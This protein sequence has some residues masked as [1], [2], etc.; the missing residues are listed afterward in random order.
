MREKEPIDIVMT[1][2]DGK[3]PVW[4]KKKQEY[5]REN[6]QQENG[7][8]D[9][10]EERYRDWGTL[11]Y[12][13]RGVEKYAPWVRNIYFVTEGHYPQW[14]NRQHPK[15]KM[16][17]H[18]DFIPEE[19]LPTFN[20]HTIEWNFHRIKGLSEQFIYFND[21][22]FLLNKTQPEYFF[23]N[24][25]PKDML[26]FQPVIA[27]PDNPVMSYI[28]LNNIVTLS[29]Y[30]DKREN[31]RKQPGKYFHIG[32]PPLYF[33]YNLLELV[34]PRY[35][36]LYTVHDAAPLLKSTYELL[37]EKEGELLSKVCS[38]RLRDKED[39]SQYLIR[40]W[41][42]LSGNFYPEN[43]HRAFRLF[44]VDDQNAALVNTITRQSAK[45]IC[46]NDSN[47][48]I[49]FLHAREELETAF[50]KVFPEKSSFEK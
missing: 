10:R 25:R 50:A 44:T 11:K 29:K 15:L 4:R 49:D 6:S 3:D 27:N 46:I 22:V 45:I 9:D 18:S 21:D 8:Q 5:L 17:K 30:F 32:Y 1:W 19:Y 31:V 28:Y 26:A 24:G 34:F 33:F 13:F 20:S 43:R 36:G 16:V 48:K 37:W 35:T 47:K 2:V 41:Q 12:W 14:L 42:K 39:V 38:H 40:E 7:M 23:K